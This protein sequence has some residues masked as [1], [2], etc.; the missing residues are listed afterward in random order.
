MRVFRPGPC[1]NNLVNKATKVE[2]LESRWFYSGLVRLYYDE[3]C[4]CY[5]NRAFF[6][7]I[8]MCWATLDYAIEH[9]LHGGSKCN[10]QTL[11]TRKP[12]PHDC[13]KMEAKLQKMWVLF[14]KLSKWND[15][16][17]WVYDCFRNTF[18]HAKLEKITKKPIPG[19]PETV[20]AICLESSRGGFTLGVESTVW[21]SD[22]KLPYNER[23]SQE[24]RL[25]AGSEKV[26][27]RLLKLTT[28][29]IKELAIAVSKTDVP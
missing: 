23:V 19:Y 9:E 12:V 29:F 5:E 27:E 7:C 25:I 17:L 26:A 15:N 11:E 22:L 6:A 3:A 4:R 2:R 13:Y 28:K 14:P 21:S 16:L 24:P 18:L 10:P 8:A 1:G 20:Q